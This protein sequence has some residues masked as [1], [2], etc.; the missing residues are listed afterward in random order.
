MLNE[1]PVYIRITSSLREAGPSLHLCSYTY[2]YA[3]A[4]YR[5]HPA[6][7]ASCMSIRPAL[8]VVTIS[9]AESSD[10]CSSEDQ[11]RRARASWGHRIAA[12]S[13][14]GLRYMH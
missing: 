5:S 8:R 4:T 14:N 1:G 7:A 2:G 6:Y 10:L 12:M 9:C 13:L 3:G 11:T